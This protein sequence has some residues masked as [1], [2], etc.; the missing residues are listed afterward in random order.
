V[1]SNYEENKNKP[2]VKSPGYRLNKPLN[3]SIDSITIFGS[4]N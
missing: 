3:P 1:F 4:A 2:I